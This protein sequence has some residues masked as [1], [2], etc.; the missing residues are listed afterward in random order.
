MPKRRVATDEL[1]VEPYG[2]TVL[3]DLA[4][5]SAEARAPTAQ[6]GAAALRAKA[7]QVV[8]A[9]SSDETIAGTTAGAGGA[10]TEIVTVDYPPTGSSETLQAWSQVED[11]PLDESW[12]SALGRAA[13]PLF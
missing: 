3:A 5:R 13:V 10:E 11:E 7:D 1:A 8:D 9:E 2:A 6:S 12:G 4:V